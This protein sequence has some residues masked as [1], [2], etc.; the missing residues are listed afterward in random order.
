M[1]FLICDPETRSN[2]ELPWQIVTHLPNKFDISTVQV[3]ADRFE[4]CF[5]KG[6]YYE[7]TQISS[8]RESAILG[9]ISAVLSSNIYPRS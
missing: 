2:E 1:S 6:D 8:T 9:H 5:V 3:K 7:L 4:T